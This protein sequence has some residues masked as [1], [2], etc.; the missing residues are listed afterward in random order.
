MNSA[1]TPLTMIYP[2]IGHV[3]FVTLSQSSERSEE[4]SEG[5]RFFTLLGMTRGVVAKQLP[6]IGH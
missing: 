3:Y 1:S 6:M 5:S 4:A 2:M